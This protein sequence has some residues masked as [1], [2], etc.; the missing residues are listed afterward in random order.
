MA[1]LH[2][3]QLFLVVLGQVANQI[4]VP[5]LLE[6]LPLHDH[7]VA[8]CG[9]F[10]DLVRPLDCRD[11]ELLRSRLYDVVDCLNQAFPALDQMQAVLWR[12]SRVWNLQRPLSDPTHD[13]YLRP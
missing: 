8:L 12:A 11:F 6:L 5:L 7:R 1:L 13:I 4:T 2:F 3:L 10:L 9:K